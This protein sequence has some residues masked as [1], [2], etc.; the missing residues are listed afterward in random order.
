MSTVDVQNQPQSVP[1]HSSQPSP[2]ESGFGDNPRP[3]LSIYSKITGDAD[4]KGTERCQKDA[5]TI[6]IFV[7]THVGFYVCFTLQ[8]GL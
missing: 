8:L 4:N 2:R 1:N 7:S 6:L 3:L 5:D